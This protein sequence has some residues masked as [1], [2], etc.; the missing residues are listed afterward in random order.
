MECRQ[1][2]PCVHVVR[3]PSVVCRRVEPRGREEAGAHPRRRRGGPS[4]GDRPGLQAGDAGGP[5]CRV[6]KA[7]LHG[8]GARTR[9]DDP[10]HRLREAGP[11]RREDAG[12]GLQ[13]RHTAFLLVGKL[14]EA[15]L[16]ARILPVHRP[17]DPLKVGGQAVPP[18]AFHTPGPPPS[19]IR[20]ALPAS[21]IRGDGA[22]HGE[23]RRDPGNRPGGAVGNRRL[24]SEEGA[25][26]PRA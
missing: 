3:R 18:P 1:N 14:F 17:P 12:K 22:V 9:R 7:A 8:L 24:E 26:W 6:R 21:G 5:D 19:G 15:V 4:G 11:R 13:V 2:P 23:D 20:L 16:G 10:R 25:P